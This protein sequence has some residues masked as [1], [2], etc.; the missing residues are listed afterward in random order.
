M[1]CLEQL[2]LDYIKCQIPASFDPWQFAYRE[3]RSVD[4]A[5]SVALNTVY[6]HLDKG[7]TYLHMLLIDYSSAF[8]TI[9]PLNR[10]NKL[11]LLDLCSAVC[12]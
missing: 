3:N 8:N 12:E 6:K 10:I 1:K 4:D 9:A 7:K 2:V 11:Q 5:I